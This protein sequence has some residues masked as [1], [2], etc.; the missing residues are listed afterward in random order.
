MDAATV[1]IADVVRIVKD[2]S[3]TE[4]IILGKLNRGVNNIASGKDRLHGVEK[5]A[6]LPELMSTGTV[7]TATD[8]GYVSLPAT[9]GRGLFLVSNSYGE[10][11]DIQKSFIKFIKTDPL[12][13]DS[14]SVEEVSEKGGNLYYRPI[15]SS[16]A[17][18][19]LY[20][21]RLPVDMT[22]AADSYPDGIPAGHE[23][24]LL[25]NY[26]CW[27]IYE[28]IEQGMDGK[29]PLTDKHRGLFYD[30]LS[31]LDRFLGP[32]DGEPLNVDDSSEDYI[33]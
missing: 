26:A 23:N 12:A 10:P 27:K 16:S 29:K 17:E 31:D 13:S 2:T 3:F 15:P 22:N 20:F 9:Y 5:L 24:D 18:L 33:L 21:Y 6:P 30:A 1:L 14:G 7:D 4:T 8:A 28:E 11:V 25:V 32:V 19:T